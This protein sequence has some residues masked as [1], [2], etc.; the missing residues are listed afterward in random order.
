M[1]DY[2]DTAITDALRRHMTLAAARE[3]VAE[4]NLANVDT[5]GYKAREIDFDQTLT[6]YVDEGV[7]LVK[8]NPKHLDGPVTTS[9]SAT[10]RTKEVEGDD[11]PRRDGNSVQIDKE[12]ISMTNAAMDFSR[13][14]TVLAAK[15][16]LL[17][18]AINEGR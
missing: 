12:L 13:A 15:F 17:R 16:K 5:P 2:S 1:P 3:V 10:M 18:Y 7:G 4:S 9:S 8:T 14:Q 11:E 6:K